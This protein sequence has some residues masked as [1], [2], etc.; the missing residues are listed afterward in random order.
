M[1]DQ[2]WYQKYVRERERRDSEERIFQLEGAAI[3]LRKWECTRPL[4]GTIRR[5]V[6][7][8]V[9][10]RRW[11]LEGNELRGVQVEGG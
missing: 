3:G 8:G 5:P 4:P 1:G 10:W 9:E 2:E 6:I 7:A 11:R